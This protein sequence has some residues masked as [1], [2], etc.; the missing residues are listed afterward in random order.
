MPT[1]NTGHGATI[2]FGTTG[3]TAAFRSLGGFDQ[4][5]G[6]H[7]KSHLGTTVYREIKPGDLIDPGEFEAEFFYN[8]DVQPPISSPAETITITLAKAISST[9][10]VTNGAVIAGSGFVK[11]WSTP[12]ITT[13]ELLASSLTIRWADG[14]TFT[15][16]P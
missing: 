5:R 12:T 13:D 14:P 3:F 16:E 11:K 4:D 8:P 7:D 9:G 15:D 2:A 6:E 10:T 1:F